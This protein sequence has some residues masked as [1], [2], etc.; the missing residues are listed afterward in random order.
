M[1]IFLYVMIVLVATV[2][3]AIAGLGGG[4]IIKPLFDLIGVHD[5]AAIGF[6]SSVAVFTMSVVSI[7]KQ[8]KKGF[9]FDLKTIV[10][11]SLGSLAGGLAGENVFS[12][13]TK[14]LENRLV[15]MIQ[16]ALLGVSLVF[17]LIYTL[18]KDQFKHYHIKNVFLIFLA[19]F[20]LGS[21]SV[22][23]GIGGGPLNVAALMLL[24]SY[25]MK[26]AT[27]YSLATIFFSQLSK[28]GKVVL[29]GQLT[30][31]DLTIV[32]FILIAAILG[33]YVGTVINQKL[34][35]E[36][37][38]RIYIILIVVLIGISCYNVISNVI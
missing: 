26:E 1:V 6:Y 25:P 12:L 31:F 8:L 18:K 7:V 20:F 27:V 9:H 5:A 34:D 2:S 16:A 15:K 17:I 22:F 3:G 19:G 33:G 10:F 13:V 11:I 38:T 24:F 36:K 4:V 35:N 37:I 21:V 14:S 30:H 28:L 29:T 23:L 32:P